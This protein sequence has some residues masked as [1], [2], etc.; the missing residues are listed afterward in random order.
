MS[1]G[2]ATASVHD[3]V[4]SLEA[5]LRRE[6][7]KVALV[8]EVSRA[9]SQEGD[10]DTLL[11]L[12]MDKVTELME[13]DRS[14]LYL[15]TEDG[16]QLWSK[17][18]QG[19]KRVEIRLEVGEGVAGWVAKAREVVNI[20]DAY[21]DQRF[22]PSFDL[23]SGY[24]TRSILSVPMLGA[25]GQLVGV[26]QVLNK[27]DGPFTTPDEELMTA[28]ASQAAIAI[29][30]ARLYH[31]IVAQNH[32][33]SRAR[34]DLERRTRELDALYEVEKELSAAL[35]LDDLLSRILAQAITVLNGGAGSIALVDPDGSLRFSTVQGPAAPRLIE[36]TLPHGTGLLGWSI[37]HR[38]PI[39]VD[40]PA[41][42]P[43]H[44]ADVAKEIGVSPQHM[45]VAPLIEGDDVIGG[46]EIIDQR[47][48]IRDGDGAWG[49]DDLKLLTLIA[50][51]AAG[52]IGMARRR[53]EQSN[54]DRLAS[55]GRML[56]GLLHDLKTPMTIISGY[57][58]L[59]AASDDAEQRDKYVEQIQRQFDLLTGMTRE[60]LAFARGD[61]DLVVRKVYVNRF[62]EELTTQLGAATGG[63]GIDFEVEAR[64]D[65]IAYFDEQKLL[66]V[67]HNLASN[68]IDA[69]PEGGHLTVSVELDG[70]EL[71]W[72]V[73]DTGPG[74]PPEVH[75]KMFELFAT[76]KKGGTG[77]GLAIVKKI[78]EDHHGSIRCDTGPSGTTFVIR[79]PM[80]RH[81]ED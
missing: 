3:P 17:V 69:M 37:A 31:S 9:L 77:L 71:V 11:I 7:K 54:R 79:L 76:G 16:S 43:R 65:G 12:I 74:I 49:D 32:Q 46:I 81:S 60:V 44:A 27:H 24:R 38:T 63:R 18:L 56:A 39:V 26:L 80:Q 29:E 19:E 68:A 53:S 36:R 72:S 64:Y 40:D 52:A 22:Q 47:R 48:M 2:L 34:R 45:L 1:D 78:V 13:A 10:L 50:S 41:K 30:N 51:R 21:A 5:A 33:L 62:T 61:T 58:Q 35:D 20:P 73:K 70:D 8:Q 14:T 59:M 42:D 15:V 67:F 57:S 75:A 55:I 23:K 25:L 66:R 28:L 4:R 6:Q